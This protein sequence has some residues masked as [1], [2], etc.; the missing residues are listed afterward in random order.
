MQF[1]ANFVQPVAYSP[2]NESPST[3]LYQLDCMAISGRASE[4][5]AAIADVVYTFHM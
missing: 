5:I 4:F 2:A 3:D 1:D